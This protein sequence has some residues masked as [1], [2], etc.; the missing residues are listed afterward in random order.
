MFVTYVSQLLWLYIFWLILINS[1]LGYC[2]G[3]E[4]RYTCLRVWYFT[5]MFVTSLILY[6]AYVVEMVIKKK[7]FA[8]V[9]TECTLLWLMWL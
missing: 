3:L 7:G 2:V 8:T 4:P 5:V 1:I 6:D 9:Q